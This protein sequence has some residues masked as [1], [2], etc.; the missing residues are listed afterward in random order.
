MHHM[1][2]IQIAKSSHRFI[3]IKIAVKTYG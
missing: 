3:S 1:P 2:I